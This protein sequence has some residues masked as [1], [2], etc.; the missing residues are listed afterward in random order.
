MF[1][2]ERGDRGRVPLMVVRAVRNACRKR[3][4]N[5]IGFVFWHI[6]LGIAAAVG[7]GA[8]TL[9]TRLEFLGAQLEAEGVL[10][11]NPSGNNSSGEIGEWITSCAPIF[12][13][14]ARNLSEC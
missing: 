8:A 2:S 11:D 6:L 1:Y 9:R 14:P 4:P 12:P 13:T 7:A 10:S 3:R 5:T